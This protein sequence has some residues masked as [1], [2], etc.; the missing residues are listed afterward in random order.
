MS[1]SVFKEQKCFNF[2]AVCFSGFC[3]EAADN[4]SNSLNESTAFFKK[5]F[6]SLPGRNERSPKATALFQTRR[7]IVAPRFI[8]ATIKFNFFISI[9][10]QNPARFAPGASCSTVAANA[11]DPL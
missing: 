2:H 4:L 5:S 7:V 10:D 9:K 11:A 1:H 3:V 6:L 8:R